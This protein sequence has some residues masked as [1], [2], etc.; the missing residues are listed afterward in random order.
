MNTEIQKKWKEGFV[1][2]YDCIAYGSGKITIANI[3]SEIET[4]TKQ[5]KYS[6]VP[7]CDTTLEG[8]EKYEEDIWTP[9]DIYRGS[10]THKS[11]TIVFGD[12]AMGNEGF[13]ASINEDKSLEWS[14]FFTFSNPIIKAEVDDNELICQGDGGVKIIIDL[15]DLTKIK[16]DCPES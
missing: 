1:V 2:G 15:N 11:K 10:F 14:I 7:L 9:I 3:Y 6:W 16:V 5:Y 8:L 4:E 13:V 12:G